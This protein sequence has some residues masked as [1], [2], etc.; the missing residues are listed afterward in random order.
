MLNERITENLLRDR[1]RELGYYSD[2]SI[3]LEEQKSK[4][5]RIDKLLQNA[6]KKGNNN[7]YPEFIISSKNE[8]DFVC[9]VECKAD[10]TKHQSKSLDRYSEYAVDGAKLYADYLSKEMDVL[11]IGASGQTDKELKISHYLQLKGEKEAQPVFDNEI[12]DF[13]SYVETY[14]QIRFRVDYQNLFKYVR[15]LNEKL[16]NKKI[17]EDKRAILFSGILIA[18]EDQTFFDTY[19]KYTNPQRLGNY[20]VE[21][22]VQKLKDSNIQE[23]R[24]YEMEQAFNFIKTH[25][26]L[27]DEGYLLELIKEIHEEISS[28]IKSNQ[29]FD[30]LSQA[31]VEFLK[32]ANNDKGLGIVLTPPHITS[33]FCDL[34]NITKDSIVFDN[35]CGTGGF[36]VVAM[37]RMIKLA[38]GDKKKEDSIK[39]NQL[40]GIEY[41]DHIFTL[42][43]SNMIIH[44]DGKTNIIKGDCLAKIDT[45]PNEEDKTKKK[46]KDFH[47]IRE[48]YKPDIG[49][50]NPPYST[51]KDELEFVLNNVDAL[52]KNGMCVAIVPMK[53]AL[54]QKGIGLSFKE[55][56]L[57]NHTLEAVLS[58]PDDLFYPIGTVTCIMIFKAYQPHPEGYKT[59][60][61]YWKNDGFMKQ[62]HR[63]RV[64]SGRWLS[65]KQKWI[66]S[67][68]NREAKAGFSVMQEVK[69]DDEWCAEAYM[70]TDYS[71]I[72]DQ[73]FIRTIHDFSSFQFSLGRIESATKEAI[74]SK[75]IA[76]DEKKWKW[77]RYDEV[78]DIYGGY[79]NK[80]PESV[81]D[82]EV[83]FIGA[84]ESNNGITSRHTLESIELT[85]KDGSK[86][87]HDIS[88]KIF[89]GGEYIT[90]SNNGSVGYAFYQPKDFTCSHD[91]NCIK[92]KNSKM[93][94]YVAMFLSS[95]IGL[96]RFR[97]AYGRKWRPI[98]MPSSL[99]RLPITSK[100]AP[101]WKFMENYIKSLPYSKNLE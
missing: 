28:F 37:D 49:L 83:L 66:N 27:I 15:T 81:D 89:K 65:I 93:N 53:C 52:Q 79:Y 71:N 62:K 97:W 61:G 95:I 6:S 47:G 3:I 19:A 87:N 14:R 88:K 21:S 60:F 101:D 18:L 64:D 72:S 85:S 96:E 9:I 99:I 38:S 98:R 75:K 44:G 23:S 1:F 55:K 5:A 57:K 26:A 82:G 35:C 43:C 2:S 73:N 8:N 63:G 7:G 17:P 34:A 69:A 4:T 58:M 11:F 31:Y 86:N 67:F 46:Y 16:H 39:K 74:G 50:L 20:L 59:Y 70:E 42:C 32:Y 33:L 45:T 91:V 78:F 41:Q 10:V 24:V 40:I 76:I 30:I 90:I 25:T 54:S 36:L 29:Y 51:E 56:L 77:F 100:D 12:L 48:K 92:L 13:G 68:R 22:V 80:K 94:Q 84:T